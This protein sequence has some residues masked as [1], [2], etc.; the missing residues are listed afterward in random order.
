MNDEK[1]QSILNRF[2]E[3]EAQLADPEVICDQNKA[4]KI[5]KE[6]SELAELADLIKR[7]FIIKKNMAENVEMV[8][9]GDIEL[10]ELANQELTQLE[11]QRNGLE[12][13][14]EIALLP[15]DPNDEKNVIIEIRPGAG[16]DE[17]EIFASEI[18]RMYFRFAERTG[19]KVNILES[20]GTGI[21][22]L[23]YLT[24]EVSGLK[25]YSKMKYE[26]GVHRVQ[27]IPETEKQGRVH[28]STV[29]VAVMPEAEEADVE[30]R[31]EDLRI[32]VFHSGGA[33]GQS[34]NTTDSA[35]RITH[36]PTGVVVACQDER[37]QLKNK[38]KALSILRSRI[39]AD[40][41]EKLSKE[42]RD[43]RSSQIGTGDRSEKIRTYNFPQDRV[44][45]HRINQSFHN[46]PNIMD[47]D[48]ALMLTALSTEDQSRKLA[49]VGGS[50]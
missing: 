33:G 11:T 39:L 42:R 46:I 41:E 18:S 17:S 4:N 9:T 40:R 26:S 6:K 1:L 13:S 37:S 20:Q 31:S 14:L 21:G 16:G 50:N 2:N 19:W 34:V 3:L 35:V 22:G 23:K 48:I 27:R 49:A 5:A 38:E 44:T 25:V 45:D 30:I 28:T 8:E 47:G 29:T 24:F 7:Y 12:K 10:Q 32:D 36:L 15:R 43:L